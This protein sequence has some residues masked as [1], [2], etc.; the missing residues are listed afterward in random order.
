MKPAGRVYDKDMLKLAK[1][2]MQCWIECGEISEKRPLGSSDHSSSVAEAIGLEFDWDEE[3]DDFGPQYQQ[4]EDYCHHLL[5]AVPTWIQKHLV[6][7]SK[8]VS[9]R[10]LG[11]RGSSRSG[12]VHRPVR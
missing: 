3:K 8:R 5:A 7:D 12:N 11:R 2:A 1:E 9:N 10:K 6:I 4:Q